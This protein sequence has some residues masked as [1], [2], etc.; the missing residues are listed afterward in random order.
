MAG[1][2]VRCPESQLCHRPPVRSC[3][4]AADAGPQ[5]TPP[6]PFA[7]F[8][9]PLRR[10]NGAEASGTAQERTPDCVHPRAR[11]SPE[12][13]GGVRRADQPEQR[14][15][16]GRRRRP[17][18]T[19]PRRC[20]S[21]PCSRVPGSPPP[22]HMPSNPAA[23]RG[24]RD[25]GDGSAAPAPHA[26]LGQPGPRQLAPAESAGRCHGGLLRLPTRSSGYSS[27]SARR[28]RLPLA[29][30]AGRPGRRGSLPSDRSWPGARRER[31][32]GRDSGPIVGGLPIGSG[33]PPV[34]AAIPDT[35]RQVPTAAKAKTT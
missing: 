21:R 17:A 12:S 5:A 2:P 8:R 34:A 15:A 22:T 25:P 24:F 16:A 31:A 32:A 29:R 4:A 10:R 20:P 6:S 30:L 28:D 18:V 9:P 3:P 33:R 14:P 19:G 13:I 1:A 11:G 27:A 35:Y 26:R 23:T 7:R